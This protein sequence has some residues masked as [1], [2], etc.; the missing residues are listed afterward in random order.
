MTGGALGAAGIAGF[1]FLY[2]NIMRT[3]RYGGAGRVAAPLG[4]VG[5]LLVRSGR[6]GG[7]GRVALRAL[8]VRCGVYPGRWFRGQNEGRLDR[9]FADEEAHDPNDVASS[10][11]DIDRRP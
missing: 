2:G 8:W 11:A 1:L 6:A 4:G 7:F 3:N 9:G 5:G 10:A